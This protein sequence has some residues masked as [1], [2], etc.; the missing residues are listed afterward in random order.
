LLYGRDPIQADLGVGTGI[1]TDYLAKTARVVLV[2]FS[3]GNGFSGGFSGIVRED[4]NFL[5]NNEKTTDP[6]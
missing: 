3:L 4:I 2:Q 1:P 5:D 6:V